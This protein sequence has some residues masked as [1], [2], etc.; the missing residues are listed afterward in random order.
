MN[1]WFSEVFLESFEPGRY[2]AQDGWLEPWQFKGLMK[3]AEANHW[4]MLSS[5]QWDV[6]R[7]N[8]NLKWSTWEEFANF[9]T[10][11]KK[12]SIRV[13]NKTGF[14]TIDITEAPQE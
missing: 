12:V 7:R 1:K 2:H 10:K 13:S 5:K 3:L 8:I 6:F 9:E 11:T 4:K 14:V